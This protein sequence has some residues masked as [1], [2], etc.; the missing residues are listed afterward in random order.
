VKLALRMARV[1]ALVALLA[2]VAR[3]FWFT[4]SETGEPLD[5][6]VRVVDGATG[7]PLAGAVVAT[8]QWRGLVDDTRF[9]ERV[10][11]A[12]AREA[13]FRAARERRLLVRAARTTGR[14][15]TTLAS[16]AW[17]TRSWIGPLEVGQ[18]IALPEVLVVEPARGGRVVVPIAPDTAVAEDGAPGTWRIDL[19]TVRI[20]E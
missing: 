19:G 4:E 9:A 20:P 7:A 5:V 13:E 18:R 3:V 2:L 8:V 11:V 15:E 14:A 12:L 1:L 10:A 6:T 16:T 17:V